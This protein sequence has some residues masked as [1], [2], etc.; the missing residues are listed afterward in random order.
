MPEFAWQ[1]R[2]P[3]GELVRGSGEAPDRV[4][5]ARIL[6]EQGLILTRARP[7][8][9]RR[10]RHA[11]PRTR[12]RR[13]ELI[14]LTHQL[15]DALGAGIPLVETLVEFSRTWPAPRVRGMLEEI[16]I[17]VEAGG[18]LADAL[19]R[20]P[21][22][23]PGAY[24]EAV[25]AA[26][27]SGR[28]DRVFGEL[29]ETLEWQDEIASRVTSALLYP[30]ILL[31]AVAGVATLFVTVLFPKIRPL[32]AATGVELPL[33][34]RALLAASDVAVRAWYLLPLFPLVPAVA[35][36]LAL[37]TRAGRLLRDR[38][39]LSL[40]GIR[41]V[42][43]HLLVAR[44]AR[45]AAT[46]LDAG[47]TMP[48]AL[49]V[50]G[51]SADNIPFHRAMERAREDVTAG[52]SLADALERTGFLGPLDI[53]MIAVGER[54]G[55]LV[56]ALGNLVRL[57]ERQARRAIQAAVTLLEPLLLIVMAAIVLGLALSIFL[58]IYQ[59]LD[60]IGR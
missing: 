21:R 18:G 56:R 45:T 9:R 6:G 12:L 39:K 15:A 38:L 3:T 36:G 41:Q 33:L 50:A 11:G 52:A 55:T 48:R 30:A 13:R 23:F 4:S 46:L 25:R 34:T 37:R 42:V 54:S 1:A 58:P 47:A 40:P 5:L 14:L 44:F 35:I 51:A 16:R 59:S 57:H 17:E 43:R 2:T 60:A 22:A 24:V 49:A 26:E 53:R 20:W 8:T 7:A 10:R 32:F 27:E 28:I 29:A 31:A 19:A